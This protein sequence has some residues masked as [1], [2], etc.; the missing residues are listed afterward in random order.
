MKS[1]SSAR[2]KPTISPVEI[3]PPAPRALFTPLRFTAPLPTS[4]PIRRIIE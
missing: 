2:K 3:V 1:K 4:V